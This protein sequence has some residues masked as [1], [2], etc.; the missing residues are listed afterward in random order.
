MD[1]IKNCNSYINIFGHKPIGSIDPLGLQ[2]RSNVSP[3]SYE[4]FLSCILNKTQDD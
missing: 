2:L 3:V 4:N 1:Y